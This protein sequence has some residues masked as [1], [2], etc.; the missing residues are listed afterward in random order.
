MGKWSQILKSSGDE[1]PKPQGIPTG[2]L[3]DAIDIIL[4]N[5]DR[6]DMLGY[7]IVRQD[8]IASGDMIVEFEVQISKGGKKILVSYPPR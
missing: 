5:G 2:R 4:K 6:R 7:E 3:R 1:A 8:L